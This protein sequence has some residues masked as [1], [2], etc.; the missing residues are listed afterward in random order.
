MYYI[1]FVYSQKKMITK[2]ICKRITGENYW[3]SESSDLILGKE[4]S[5]T[6][7]NKCFIHEEFL[8]SKYG[9]KVVLQQ[10]KQ[11]LMSLFA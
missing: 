7:I 8:E 9:Q 6:K 11:N 2:Q 3:T 4:Y 5:I 1:L 10:K